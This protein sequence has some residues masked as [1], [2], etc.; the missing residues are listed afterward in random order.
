MQAGMRSCGGPPACVIL[1]RRRRIG[2]AAAQGPRTIRKDFRDYSK[3]VLSSLILERQ[4]SRSFALRAQ[5]DTAS[6][7]GHSHFPVSVCPGRANL[8]AAKGSVS[9]LTRT[10]VVNFRGYFPPVE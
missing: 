3:D 7:Q 5:D 1:S 10:P 4:R 8:G 2:S 9:G 6:F